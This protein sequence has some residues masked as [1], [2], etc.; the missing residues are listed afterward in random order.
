[1]KFHDTKA[2]LATVTFDSVE[3]ALSNRGITNPSNF[4]SSLL[5]QMGLIPADEAAITAIA[6][7]VPEDEDYG[8]I[9][10]TT[11]VD[12]R[13]L[14]IIGT[15]IDMESNAYV[16]I[17]GNRVFKVNTRL[18]SQYS[19]DDIGLAL[20]I[21]YKNAK[22][23]VPMRENI[24]VIV[25]P[26]SIYLIDKTQKA[27]SI[28]DLQERKLIKGTFAFVNSFE[29]DSY[30][31]ESQ[32]DDTNTWGQGLDFAYAGEHGTAMKLRDLTNLTGLN[33]RAAL[34]GTGDYDYIDFSVTFAGLQNSKEYPLLV[35]K[36]DNTLSL[37]SHLDSY[38]SLF[39]IK[40]EPSS[41]ATNLLWLNDEGM[42]LIGA[43]DSNE[44]HVRVIDTETQQTT[45][46]T[47]Q[48]GNAYS[49]DTLEQVDTKLY[50]K[51]TEDFDLDCMF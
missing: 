48:K 24:D 35:T 10:K 20:D 1:M 27:E 15:L 16:D 8:I 46:I 13:E 23:T 32:E 31:S 45:D 29:V 26:G 7:F 11:N 25:T 37:E 44:V 50:Q 22:G 4:P 28:Q 3:D 36:T 2:N 42:N 5:E 34:A 6:A 18:P 43:T 39:D 40:G 21:D 33:N 17:R 12:L 47:L 38:I 41:S 30:G 9:A 19:R 51:K 14:D 49:A